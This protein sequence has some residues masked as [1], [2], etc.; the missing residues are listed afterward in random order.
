M[1]GLNGRLHKAEHKI[2]KSENIQPEAQRKTR[3]ERKGRKQRAH[4]T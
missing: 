3:V 4:G 1:D 2:D